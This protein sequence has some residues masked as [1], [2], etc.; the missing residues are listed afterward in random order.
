MRLS[1][2]FH[3]QHDWVIFRAMSRNQ[4]VLGLELTAEILANVCEALCAPLDLEMTLL[5][6]T[7]A[8]ATATFPFLYVWGQLTSY[9]T[10]KG[11]RQY[12]KGQTS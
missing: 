1:R 4:A 9:G 10:T 7:L 3:S 2:L 5:G 8:D 6:K 12:L 11:T